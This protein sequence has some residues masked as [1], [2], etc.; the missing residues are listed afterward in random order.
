[1]SL[2]TKDPAARGCQRFYRIRNR[3]SCR[4]LS[5]SSKFLRFSKIRTFQVE[6]NRRVELGKTVRTKLVEA[7]QL[8]RLKESIVSEN[9]HRHQKRGSHSNPRT[10]RMARHP[11]GPKPCKNLRI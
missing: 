3:R 11:N 9:H 2:P 6:L 8:R 7:I 10:D 4:H 5:G 1:M